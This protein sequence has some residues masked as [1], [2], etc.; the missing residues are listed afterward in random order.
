MDSIMQ[1]IAAYLEFSSRFACVCVCVCDQTFRCDHLAGCDRRRC[2]TLLVSLHEILLFIIAC[3]EPHFSP[4]LVTGQILTRFF[5]FIFYHACHP[6]VFVVSFDIFSFVVYMLL[7]FCMKSC[8][9]VN[10]VEMLINDGYGCEPKRK[11]FLLIKYYQLDSNFHSVELS[12][13]S[14]T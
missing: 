8:F 14:Y 1:N 4:L 10:L 12:S 2:S 7:Q 6:I 11:I 13:Y 9:I 3:N 5:F